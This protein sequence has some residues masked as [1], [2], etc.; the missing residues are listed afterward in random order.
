MDNSVTRY[1][2]SRLASALNEVKYGGISEIRLRI[3]RPPALTSQNGILYL[4]SSGGVSSDPSKA[5][6]VTADEIRKV[7]DAVCQYSLHSWHSQIAQC[8]VTVP[9]GHRVGISG[10][11]VISG[12]K[13]E[14]VRDIG[15][16]NFRIAREIS[17]AA[18]S[19]MSTAMNGRLKSI[20]LCGRPGSGKTTVLRDLCRQIGNKYPV[21]LI[22][23]R[24][25]LA[26]C[27]RGAPQNDVGLNTDV[28]TGF[29]KADGILTALRVMSP[30][31]IICDEIGGDD[32]VSA[33]L[34]SG[35][36]GIY[37]AATVHAGSAEDIF[38]RQNIKRLIDA[39]IFDCFAFIRGG[40]AEKINDISR[41]KDRRYNGGAAF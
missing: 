22:D 2:P 14:T 7:F 30:R 24:C 25:E 41:I 40:K 1:F 34:A 6:T 9:G 15:S 33:L 32:D 20:L 19:I 36:C 12:D 26:A 35:N 3:S 27:S 23:E 28:F 16:I 5:M 10:T 31:M 17:G 18:D 8:C 21:A 13:I 11:A 38:R 4:M 29:S 39:D 37:T